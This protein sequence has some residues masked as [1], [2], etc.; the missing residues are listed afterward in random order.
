MVRWLP[1]YPVTALERLRYLRDKAAWYRGLVGRIENIRYD[2]AIFINHH[3]AFS[4][5]AYHPGHLLWVTDAPRLS[6]EDVAPYARVFLSDPGYANEVSAV[7]GAE[8]YSGELGF[9]LLPSIHRPADFS[10]ARQGF[11]FIGNT[12]PKRSTHLEALL[13]SDAPMRIYG[14][15]FLRS[16]LFLRHPWSCRPSVGNESMG[17]IYA[18]HRAS[19]NIHAEVLRCGTNMRTFECA[20]YGIPQLVEYRPGLETFFEPER[21]I[22]VYHDVEELPRLALRLLE[23]PKAGAMAER[24]RHRALAEHTYAHRV[25][26]LLASYPE[27][28]VELRRVIRIPS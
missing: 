15:Y 12:D 25:Q 10:R 24:A 3:R 23:D 11:C 13:R 9:G 18:R 21:E 4:G 26:R 22:L 16:G 14:N 1:T 27:L 2:V 6:S 5:L 17:S 28:E 7:L 19:L 20:G 8:G